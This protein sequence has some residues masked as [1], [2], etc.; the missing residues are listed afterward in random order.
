MVKL[1]TV[2]KRRKRCDD[3]DEL[4]E[5]DDD[6]QESVCHEGECQK[7]PENNKCKCIKKMK[8]IFVHDGCD[9]NFEDICC[10]Y[11]DDE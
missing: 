5:L 2:Y 9:F 4:I 1:S 11:E 8:K 7:C 3:C 10:R 6:F